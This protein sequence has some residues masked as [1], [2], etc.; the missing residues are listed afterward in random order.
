MHPSA[1][2]DEGAVISEGCR[3]WHF[4]HICADAKIGARASLG[5]NVFVAGGVC[6]GDNCKIQNNVSVYEGVKLESDVFC[7]PSVVFTNVYNPDNG[8]DCLGLFSSR[9]RGIQEDVMLSTSAIDSL[10]RG[11]HTCGMGWLD[12]QGVDSVVCENGFPVPIN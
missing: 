11:E 7:G 8:A 3:I 2:V 10:W 6:I 9:A 12:F 5:Q 1:I 4:S